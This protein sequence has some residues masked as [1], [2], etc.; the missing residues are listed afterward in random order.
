MCISLWTPFS[1]NLLPSAEAGC[2]NPLEIRQKC[3]NVAGPLSF[4]CDPGTPHPKV[5]V[6]AV[7]TPRGD[8]RKNRRDVPASCLGLS[9]RLNDA[10]RCLLS[11][12]QRGNSLRLIRTDHRA[13]FKDDRI[14][15]Y[16]T[17]CGTFKLFYVALC[18]ISTW[19]NEA[20]LRQCFLKE[21]PRCNQ[22][23]GPAR[24]QGRPVKEQ[25]IGGLIV[26]P[27]LSCLIDQFHRTVRPTIRCRAKLVST[28]ENGF[29]LSL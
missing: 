22:H 4:V 10:V 11:R 3:V 6:S 5:V 1:R 26:S 25:R 20:G 21:E 18:P 2:G 29:N 9:G 16:R 15:R 8:V 17:R 27:L 12:G 28:K 24:K 14:Q 19:S 13:V 23:S 7:R